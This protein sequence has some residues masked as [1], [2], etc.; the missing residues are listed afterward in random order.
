M[1]DM[2]KKHFF[3]QWN[4]LSLIGNWP[5][6][7]EYIINKKTLLAAI[8]ETRFLDTDSD[9]YKLT[10]FGYSLYCDNINTNPRQGGTALY[11]SNNLLH[12][13]ILFDTP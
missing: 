5:H 7:R 3:L 8:Q 13:Q 1:S 4:A 12:H 10:P 6:F 2:Q 9:D 11:I